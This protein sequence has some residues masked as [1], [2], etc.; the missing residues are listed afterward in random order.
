VAWRLYR[1]GDRLGAVW[2]NML[3]LVDLVVAVGIGFLA[4]SGP[5]NLLSVTP[6]TEAIAML[7][8]VLI[9]TTAVPLAAAL[10]VVSLRRL[11]A[12]RTAL[13]VAG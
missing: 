3:G 4:A 12:A 2:F 13:P 9:P 1:G 8:L 5:A 7:P 10:H 11:R 6:S